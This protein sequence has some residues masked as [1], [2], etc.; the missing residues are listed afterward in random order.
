MVSLTGSQ[1]KGRKD[2][3]TGGVESVPLAGKKAVKAGGFVF[4]IGGRNFRVTEV[5]CI[6]GF[7]VVTNNSRVVVK[8][9]G[10]DQG[11]GRVS[12]KS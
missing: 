11:G 2:F 9:F 8:D 6:N 3:D 10:R 5:L 7:C 4:L 12:G 1:K